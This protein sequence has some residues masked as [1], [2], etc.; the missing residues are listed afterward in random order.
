MNLPLSRQLSSSDMATYRTI[1]LQAVIFQPYLASAIFAL[2]PVSS[3]GLGT[4]AIDC[5]GRVYLDPERFSAW[6]IEQSASVLIHEVHHLLRRH[7]ERAD[8]A[9]VPDHLRDVW[10][11]AGDLAINDDLMA[12]GLP[13]PPLFVPANFGFF[14]GLSEESYF[15]KL[16]KMDGVEAACRCGSGSGGSASD[17]LEDSSYDTLGPADLAR[18]RREVL[19]RMQGGLSGP[20]GLRTALMTKPP[21]APW[22]TLLR[23]L[24]QPKASR[25]GERREVWQRPNRRHDEAFLL[26]GIHRRG[27]NIGIVFDT[28]ASMDQHLLNRAASEISG[29][30]RSARVKAITLVSCDA[31]AS[32]PTSISP[33]TILS[34]TGGGGTDLT[35]GIDALSQ[36]ADPPSVIIVLT[37]G[38]TPWPNEAPQHCQL[39]CAIFDP[40]APLPTGRGIEA[41]YVK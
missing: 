20:Q 3:N 37:D 22:Q 31:E 7:F 40:S 33:T 16:Q 28:S 13:L 17:E 25:S 34:L 15:V 36:L 19:A 35:F 6:S 4:F 21:S 14:N 24:L 29:I 27:A 38:W 30:L 1:R 18:I 8:A 5:F 39:I 26:P 41:L 32:V 9:K 2:L 12:Q 10:N 23:R 11:L